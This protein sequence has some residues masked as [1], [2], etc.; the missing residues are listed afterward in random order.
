[1]SAEIKMLTGCATWHGK[2]AEGQINFGCTGHE[3]MMRSRQWPI[4][5]HAEDQNL[6]QIQLSAV[7]KRAASSEKLG[8]PLLPW[9]FRISRH[10]F[11]PVQKYWTDKEYPPCKTAKS[12]WNSHMLTNK[13]QNQK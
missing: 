7:G 13:Y 4:N 10:V 5:H 12:I 1:M 6:G 9:S 3:S 11:C 2:H 8:E